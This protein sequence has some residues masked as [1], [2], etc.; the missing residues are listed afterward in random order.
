M[1]Y[2]IVIDIN[3]YCFSFLYEFT[4]VNP[5]VKKLNQKKVFLSILTSLKGTPSQST[6]NPSHIAASV[7]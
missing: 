2:R 6:I 5:K 1:F 4:R 3:T 7:V